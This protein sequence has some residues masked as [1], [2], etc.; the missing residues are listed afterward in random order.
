[1]RTV[2]ANLSI[3]SSVFLLASASAQQVC[4]AGYSDGEWIDR[5]EYVSVVFQG[6]TYWCERQGVYYNMTYVS[7]DAKCGNRIKYVSNMEVSVTS[8]GGV[9]YRFFGND[10]HIS[11]KV[12]KDC[13][14]GS[15]CLVRTEHTNNAKSENVNVNFSVP[16]TTVTINKRGC[17][18]LS[19]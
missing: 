3:L 18:R 12:T 17:D 2:L 11:N 16:I 9:D 10:T 5:K 4:P 6:N 7:R 13:S 14:A 8:L 1:M 19:F 15:S